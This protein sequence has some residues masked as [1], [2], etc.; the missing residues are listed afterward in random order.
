[1]EKCISTKLESN[2]YDINP[3]EYWDEI[4]QLTFIKNDFEYRL[5]KLMSLLYFIW[6][7]VQITSANLRNIFS[8]RSD[9]CEASQ[10]KS[11]QLS[12]SC[13]YIIYH[14]WCDIKQY[15]TSHILR[16]R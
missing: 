5:K 1:M 9:T 3:N 8:R 11:V 12:L 16:Q 7:Q 10:R 15:I 13:I 14:P 6:T 4:I 2:F